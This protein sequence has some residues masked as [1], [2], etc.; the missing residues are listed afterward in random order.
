[1]FSSENET[2]GGE[3]FVYR[4][5]FR[6][7]SHVA[8]LE[9]FAWILGDKMAENPKISALSISGNDC[10]FKPFFTENEWTYY[11][12]QIEKPSVT[13]SSVGRLFDALSFVLGF[14][15]AI[16]FEGEAAMHV[17]KLA[18]SAVSVSETGLTDYLHENFSAKELLL[19]IM[20]ELPLHKPETI[21]LNFHYTLIKMIEKI[22]V[23]NHSKA[24]AFSGGVF[25]NSLLVDLAIDMLSPNFE[26]YFHEN[27]SP[28]DENIAFGQLNYYLNKMK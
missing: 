20:D 15:R 12:R 14:N 28:N 16:S 2:W 26:L 3:F 11:T 13:T 9:Q 24:I 27:I 8:Q 1:G 23:L 18:Q 22:A 4:K 10:R 7:F 19:R 17:E 25:Q 5:G 21:A 6:S